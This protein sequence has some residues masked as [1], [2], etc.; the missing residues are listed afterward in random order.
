MITLGKNGWQSVQGSDIRGSIIRSRNID[1]SET[2]YVTLSRKPCTIFNEVAVTGTG[3]ASFTDPVAIAAD[4]TYY[5][6]VTTTNVYGLTASET[7]TSFA[8]VTTSGKPTIVETSDALSYNGAIAVTGG[9]T[10][11]YLSSFNGANGG[12]TWTQASD[13]SLSSSYPHPLCRIDTRR[14]L[15]VGDG[16]VVKQT[17]A[18]AWTDDDDNVLTLPSEYEVTSMRFRGTKVGIGTRNV[19]GGNAMFFIWSGSGTSAESGWPVDAPWIYA[20]CEYGSSF[21]VLTSAGQL[22]RFN[23][24]GFDVLAN[25]PV[26]YT[27]HTW[28]ANASSQQLGKAMNRGM[29]AIG[30]VIYFTIEG[31]P[32][33]LDAPQGEKQPGGLWVYDPSVGLHHRAGFVAESYRSLSISTLASSIFTFSE[34][35]GCETGDAVW[36]DTVSNIA[37]LTEGRV[38][39][40]IRESATQFKLALSP[41]DAQ[42]GRFII[43][44]GTIS[45]DKLAVET[46]SSVGSI[47]QVVPGPVFGFTK[48]LLSKF[49]ASEVFFSGN[50]YG[51]TMNGPLACL[52]SFGM[53]RNVGSIVTPKLYGAGITDVFQKIVSNIRGLNLETDQVVIKYRTKERFGLPTPL[54]VSNSGTAVWVTPSQFTIDITGKDIQSIAVGDEVE[55]THGAGAGYTAHITAINNATTTWTIDIDESIPDIA[56]SD[57]SDILIDNWT[58]LVTITKDSADIDKG[59]HEETVGGEGAWVQFKIELRGRDVALNIV[60]VVNAVHKQT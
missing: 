39:Y 22:L 30:D 49:F 60:N 3:S 12:G 20:V 52:M 53:G 59:F 42:E 2:G 26:Y 16:N 18:A 55:I 11:H 23:G 31:E 46:M 47:G 7:G 36:A 48:N 10:L 45:G 27:P 17:D 4:G 5:Y 1:L 13:F 21:A 43:C 28:V 33:G 50:A 54:R 14:T 8:A 25:L 44:S 34:N 37:A 6:I 57:Q 15:A 38:Y 9:A 56:A 35:H 32:R 51:P 40:A 19:S 29:W 58:K 24:G 41:S